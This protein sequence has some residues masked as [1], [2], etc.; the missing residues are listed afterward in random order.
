M[1]LP[2]F[3]VF[4][5][6]LRQHGIYL[7]Y[8]ITKQTTTDKAFF[9]YYFNITRKPAFA[10]PLPTLANTKKASW[11]DL[12][13]IQNEQ[14][15]WLLCVAK[16]RDWSRKIAPL[17]NL[18]RASLL[19]EYENLQ[20]KQNWTAKSTNLDENAGKIK[21]VFVIGAALWAEKLGRC[22]ENYRSWK[23]TLGKLVVMVN[24]ETIW[25]EFWMK[26]A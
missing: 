18:T 4:C 22:P 26:G 10:P 15:H 17:S 2:H 6:L 24:L 16:N 7:F 13:S 8:I 5:D 19:F 9:Y 12:W 14:F 23:N 3:D 1:F 20:R 25:F 11:R 21:S